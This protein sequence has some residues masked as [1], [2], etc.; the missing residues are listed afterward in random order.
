M[1]ALQG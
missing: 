1:S